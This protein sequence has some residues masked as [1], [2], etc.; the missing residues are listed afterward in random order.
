MKKEI[1]T[2]IT[3]QATPEKIWAILTDFDRYP[4]WNPF[5][6]SISGNVEPNC[7]IRVEIVPPEG[8]RMVFK[9]VVLRK[10]ENN[11]LKWQGKL[12][13]KGL[14][15][16]EHAFELKRNEDGTTTFCHSEKFSGILVRWIDLKQTEAGF[17]Q[18]NRKLKE[19]AE[20]VK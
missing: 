12:F 4:D 20:V 5:I 6:R 10:E 2:H 18:M 16:G 11:E 14:F 1:R 9:P 17:E 3:I 15:D 8:K 13:F 19:L 7:N